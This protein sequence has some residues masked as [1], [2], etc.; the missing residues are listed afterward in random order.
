MLQQTSLGA[1][2]RNGNRERGHVV[3]SPG[4]SADESATA[5]ETLRGGALS[6]D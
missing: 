5:I 2:G 1:I 6:S 3:K 4:L